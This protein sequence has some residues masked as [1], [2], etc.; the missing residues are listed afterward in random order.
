MTR[1]LCSVRSIAAAVALSGLGASLGACGA[2]EVT[3]P[4][5][6]LRPEPEAAGDADGTRRTDCD[7]LE[8]G[9]Q[10]KAISYDERSIPESQRLSEQA[11]AQLRAAESA[12]VE[13]AVREDY[14]SSA[15]VALLTALAADPY[16][17]QATYTLAGAY[18]RIG[19]FQCSMNLLT[20]LLQM[21]TH[22][23]KKADVEAQLDRL[24]GR[25]Q[26]LDPDFA[27]MRRDERFRGLIQRMCDGTN[28]PNCVLGAQGR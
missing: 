11:R 6:P 4:P 26:Q 7:P 5:P 16:N 19:R 13:R 24:L 10:I 22:F 1:M 12:E 18:A 14:V 3:A 20:R 9:E 8:Q 2:P 27:D 28:D 25:K 21:R 23:A 15:V 17:V